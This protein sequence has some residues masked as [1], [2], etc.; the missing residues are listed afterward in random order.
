MIFRIS[1]LLIV[2]GG[3][4]SGC[5]RAT[6]LVYVHNM[7]AGVDLKPAGEGTVRFVVGYDRETYALVPRVNDGN[8]VEA[9][10]LAAVS[11]VKIEGTTGFRFSHVIATGE[12]AIKVAKSPE[13]LQDVADKT[14]SDTK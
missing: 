8:S 10:N 12:A 6:H 7:V 11:K 9:M 1:T 3:V 14:F 5:G 2:I 13:V 4:L